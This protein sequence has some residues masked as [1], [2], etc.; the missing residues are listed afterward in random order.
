MSD[1]KLLLINSRKMDDRFVNEAGDTMTGGLTLATG[2][3]SIFPL[4]VV[5]GDLLTDP[6]CGAIE[7]SDRKLYVT[8]CETRRVLD[9]TSDVAVET[10]TVA[11]TADETTMW[12]GTMPADSL[13]AGNV[14][15]FHADG[16]VT[17]D[18]NHADNNI[19]IRVRVGGTQVVS[20]TPET[21]ALTNVMW[22]I[23]A[24]ATQRTV[25]ASGSRAIHLH[26]VVGD[27]D[28]QHAFG[29]ASIDTTANMDVTVTAEW[30][31]AKVTNTISLYQGFM[32]YKN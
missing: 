13:I 6:E 19:T 7:F 11:D 23:N 26:L 25:G 18:G 3:S 28:E 31:T 27:V 17:N 32:E 24:N 4:K 9:R 14:L 22:H 12:T 30:A 10:V 1:P 2:S 5:N 8:F 29:I 20:L 21:K 15:K 16:A